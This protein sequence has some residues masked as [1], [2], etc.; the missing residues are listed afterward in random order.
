MALLSSDTLGSGVQELQVV[1]G[2]S[3]PKGGPVAR[4]LLGI[5]GSVVPELHV[6]S[7]TSVPK[8]PVLGNSGKR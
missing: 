6:V 8:K 7:G 3:V 1:G 4:D 2:T 5:L